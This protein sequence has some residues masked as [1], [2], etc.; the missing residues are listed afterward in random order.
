MRRVAR[1]PGS[2]LVPVRPLAD[3]Y[4]SVRRHRM[5]HA[6][7]RAHPFGARATRARALA[8][9]IRGLCLGGRAL[10]CEPDI[11]LLLSDYNVLS[12]PSNT[13]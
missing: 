8:S 6:L 1:V 12:S 10:A 2:A 9:D 5:H 11:S 13:P 7:V 4:S 3:T